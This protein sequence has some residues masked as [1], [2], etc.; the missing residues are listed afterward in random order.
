MSFKADR[1]DSGIALFF[2]VLFVIICFVLLINIGRIL[3]N[4]SSVTF[5]GFLDFVSNTNF[6]QINVNIRDFTIVS[7]WGLFNFL[8]DFINIF[9][10]L[11][12]VTF[13]MV[14][15]LLN[16]LLFILNFVVYILG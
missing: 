16:L 4:G 6:S 7:D 9:A 2:R 8:K 1:V 13:F 14:S 11:M 3:F 5:S 10:S 12:G 15:N